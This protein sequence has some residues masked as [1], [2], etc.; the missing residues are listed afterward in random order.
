MM[1]NTISAIE[2]IFSQIGESMLESSVA[3][4][5]LCLIVPSCWRSLR[6]GL[7][8]VLLC[9]RTSLRF[10]L[11]QIISSSLECSTQ[12]GCPSIGHVL[13]LLG[14]DL[15][16]INNTTPY[17]HKAAKTIIIQ[18]SI[19]ISIDGTPSAAG[20]DELTCTLK[21]WQTFYYTPYQTIY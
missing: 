20:V 17:S 9:F 6:R 3:T 11:L 14:T 12:Q 8:N 10:K 5:V 7:N 1:G 2:S 21:L 16:F 19:H 4:S 13:C 18:D 15:C